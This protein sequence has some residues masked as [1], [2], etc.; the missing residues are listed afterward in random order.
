MRR[1][2]NPTLFICLMILLSGVA[3]A[4]T[5][6]ASEKSDTAQLAFRNTS[7]FTLQI[8]VDGVAWCKNF[9]A[10]GVCSGPPIE[11]R[12]EHRVRIVKG[13]ND[14]NVSF[15]QERCAP[16]CYYEANN[17]GFTFHPGKK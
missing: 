16:S 2:Q 9:R 8:Y 10:P 6:P 13:A 5:P 14:Y 17:D 4:Q 1:F 15:A 3:G 7:R 12:G 11:G